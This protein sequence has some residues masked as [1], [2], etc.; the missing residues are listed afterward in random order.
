MGTEEE[1]RGFIL[2]SEGTYLKKTAMKAVREIGLV[3]INSG[4]K[5]RE[6]VITQ[7]IL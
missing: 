4:F 5:G 2:C 6:V 3:S 7:R 1:V